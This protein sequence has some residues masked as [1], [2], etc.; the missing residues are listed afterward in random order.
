MP[1]KK[2]Q[3]R[4]TVLFSDQSEVDEIQEAIDKINKQNKGN[5]FIKTLT[6]AHFIKSSALM[7]ARIVNNA[8]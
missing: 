8:N 2:K 4:K 5:D 6:L 3:L 7:K 1:T